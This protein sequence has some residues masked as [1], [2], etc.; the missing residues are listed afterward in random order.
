MNDIHNGSLQFQAILFVDDTNLNS[1]LC[2]LDVNDDNDCIR[3]QLST[4]INKE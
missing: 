1:T 3:L 2:S 4:N